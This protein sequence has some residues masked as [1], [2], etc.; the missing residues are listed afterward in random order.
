MAGD[1]G[2]PRGGILQGLGMMQSA[3]ISQNWFPET[4]P[5]RCT[6]KE[7][8]GKKNEKV[9]NITPSPF[10]DLPGSFVSYVF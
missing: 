4:N 8:Q 10:G 2:G 6:Q 7:L 1:P 5:L 3:R 9:L